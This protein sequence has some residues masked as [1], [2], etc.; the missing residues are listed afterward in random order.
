MRTCNILSYDFNKMARSEISLYDLNSVGGFLGF[1]IKTTKSSLNESLKICVNCSIMLFGRRLR[2]SVVIKSNRNAVIF[3]KPYLRS[4][5]YCKLTMITVSDTIVSCMLIPMKKDV[6]A[7]WVIYAGIWGSRRME[8][9]CLRWK[10][11]ALPSIDEREAE[12]YVTAV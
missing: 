10:N 2:T 11:Q 7:R 8:R 6:P 3:V 4:S 5:V 9:P 1:G 12:R